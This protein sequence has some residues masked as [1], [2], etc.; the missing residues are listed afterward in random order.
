MLQPVY[1]GFQQG[2]RAGGDA[3]DGAAGDLFL[4]L[5][6]HD[7]FA[8]GGGEVRAVDR[9]KRL[10]L[11]DVLIGCIG[12]DFLDE[13]REAHLNI[14]EVG[15]VHG[16]VAGRADFIIDRFARDPSVLHADALQALRGDLDG[17]EGRLARRD[18]GSRA[19]C[20]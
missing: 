6:C 18:C 15:F 1:G 7:I 8:L 5:P 19:V 2:G 4:I 3:G 10:P 9:E 13:T 11:G 17:H 16:D 20:L 12:K 14:G